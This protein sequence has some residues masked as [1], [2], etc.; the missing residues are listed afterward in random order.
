MPLCPRP[1]TLPGTGVPPQRGSPSLGGRYGINLALRGNPQ[2]DPTR[3]LRHAALPEA[4]PGP[5]QLFH[6]S[7]LLFQALQPRSVPCQMFPLPPPAA[8]VRRG[9]FGA[10]SGREVWKQGLISSFSWATRCPVPYQQQ[11]PGTEVASP[12]SREQNPA[13]AG[14]L[15]PWSR[16]GT[17]RQAGSQGRGSPAWERSCAAAEEPGRVAL[18]LAGDKAVLVLLVGTGCPRAGTHRD[19][20]T[21]AT[22][23]ARDV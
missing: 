10:A 8:G 19:A 13:A 11:P 23:A 5:R 7:F 9:R 3:V 21:G 16:A 4:L 2:R 18:A 14:G 17:R 20:V 6:I 15:S 1:Q 12:W 22:S